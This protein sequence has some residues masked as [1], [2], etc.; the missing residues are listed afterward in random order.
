MAPVMCDE[1]HV[2]VPLSTSSV[3]FQT[4][5]IAVALRKHFACLPLNQRRLSGVSGCGGG[6]F[7]ERVPIRRRC[8]RNAGIRICC[9][10]STWPKVARVA[11]A[12]AAGVSAMRC[13]SEEHIMSGRSV[14]PA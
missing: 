8:Q 12:A 2:I 9:V 13:Q 1:A 5:R 4:H 3:L 6:G 10:G 14:V 11:H 7:G